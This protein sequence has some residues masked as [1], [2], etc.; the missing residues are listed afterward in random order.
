MT[1]T[2]QP[3]APPAPPSAGSPV[4]VL[5]A[6][7]EVVAGLIH[8][9]W[10]ARSPQ[11]LLDTVAATERL[12]SG[13]DAVQLHVVEEVDARSAA[14]VAGWAS[15]KD[16]LTAV[17]GGRTGAGRRLLGLARAVG[18]DRGATGA[19]LAAGVIS[20]DQA[21]AVVAV[22]DR[23]P[24]TPGLRAAA[25]ELLLEE[26]RTRDAGEL[27]KLGPY[28]WQRLDPD[29]VERREE[30]ALERGERA[31]HAGRFLSLT[32]DGIGGVRLRGRGTVEDVAQLTAVLAPLAG[33]RPSSDPGACGGIPATTPDSAGSASGA[34]RGPRRG[35][36]G[37][38]ECAHD[39]RDPR[40][41]GTRMWDA[42]IEAAR[43]LAGTEV[44]PHSHG[45]SPRVGV[46][47]DFEALR[48]GVGVGLLDTGGTLS[49]AAVRRLACDAEV[50]PFVLGSR[51][52][53]LDVGRTSRLVTLG[54]WL[55][56]IVRDRHCAFP[57]CSRAPF[58]C[59]AHHIRH[60]ADGGATALG[61]LVLL[62]RAHHT[63]MHT[64]G[65]EIRLNPDDQRP[66]FH[67]PATLDPLR[68]PL[69]RR[70]LRD[71]PKRGSPQT[72]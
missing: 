72:E 33:P 17:T 44:L 16:Y 9:L 28:V 50:L 45:V 54:L 58:A 39:G 27:A 38:A 32:P 13:L 63:V 61:N 26:A 22:V 2:L 59:D 69:R 25:E 24:T 66:D 7:T 34:G 14:Q 21:E 30:R 31:A 1:E 51:S 19:A 52:Q 10:A 71:Q 53:L 23:L 57:G 68:R 29:G 37:V 5:E 67:P 49:A 42:L 3:P 20:R 36:C 64:T 18:G 65:W 47:I 60:W 46:T 35:S 55:A 12:R 15:T 70:R 11:E 8:S 6:V 43:R 4:E 40:E 62:C 41:H 56:L 48:T